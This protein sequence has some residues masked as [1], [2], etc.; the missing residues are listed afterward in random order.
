MGEFSRPHS[1]SVLPADSAAGSSVDSSVGAPVGAS[2]ESSVGSSVE[3]DGGAE[4]ISAAELHEFL[5]A[6]VLGAP[7]DPA[8]KRRLR[9]RLWELV[10]SRFSKQQGSRVGRDRQRRSDPPDTATAS[11]GEQ[12]RPKR[13]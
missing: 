11:T 9:G 2:I 8:F 4:A 10:Q 1:R 3:L 6:D 5:A 13:G 12:P 7:A